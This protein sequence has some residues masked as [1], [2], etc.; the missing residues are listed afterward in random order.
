MGRHLGEEKNR[1]WDACRRRPNH[2]D[3]YPQRSLTILSG[4]PAGGWRSLACSLRAVARQ[5]LLGHGAAQQVGVDRLDDT[6][7]T[8]GAGVSRVPVALPGEELAGVQ[9]IGQGHGVLVR[10]GRVTGRPD[11]EDRRGSLGVELL[12][13]LGAGVPPGLA[14]QFGSIERGREAR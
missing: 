11:H 9:L 8:P 13:R 2:G 4:Q 5:P 12:G 3:A 1:G 7:A 10:S 6:G 14:S